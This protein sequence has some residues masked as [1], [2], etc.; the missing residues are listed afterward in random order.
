MRRAKNPTERGFD[1]YDERRLSRALHD[2]RDVRTYR[3]IQALWLVAQGRGVQ[4]AAEI[5]GVKPWAVY[6]WIRTYL[7][8]HDPDRLRDAPRPGRPRAAPAITDKRIVQE[9]GRDPMRLGYNSTGWTVS[10]LA[11]HLRQK[12]GGSLS[13]RTLRRRMHDLTLCW[14]RP[15]YTY[16]NKDPNR[17]QKKG[18]LSAA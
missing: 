11:D 3:R 4:E 16:A 12:Y 7:Q 10:L 2:V 1:P 6:A 15:R 9:F 17:T 8:T 13:V 18:A 5:A 14:K